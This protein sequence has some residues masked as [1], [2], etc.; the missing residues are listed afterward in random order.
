MDNLGVN[1][2]NWYKVLCR[3]E[4]FVGEFEADGVFLVYF[5]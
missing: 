3:D 5:V 4:D 2:Y 1:Y